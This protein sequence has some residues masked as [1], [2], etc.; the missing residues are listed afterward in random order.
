MVIGAPHFPHVMDTGFLP[1]I[2][3]GGSAQITWLGI[4]SPQFPH[5]KDVAPQSHKIEATYFWGAIISPW[6]LLG[7]DSRQ[8]AQGCNSSYIEEWRISGYTPTQILEYGMGCTKP[9]SGEELSTVV[10]KRT[11]QV[12]W[13]LSAKII[14]IGLLPPSPPFPP[15]F[16]NGN[17]LGGLNTAIPH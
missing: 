8:R 14:G 10:C 7:E 6:A 3:F 12:T 9:T 2:I 15:L 13:S 1:N 16:G 5:S 11:F 17:I 4:G